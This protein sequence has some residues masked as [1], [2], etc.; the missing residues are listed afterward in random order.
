MFEALSGKWLVGVSGQ[1]DSMALLH[2]CVAHKMDVMACIINYGT[3]MAAADEI[4]YVQYFCDAHQIPLEVVD[5]PAIK[6][7]FQKRARDF[8]Y[9]TFKALIEQHQAQGVLLAHH[10]DDHL[11][12][13][14]WQFKRGH[15]VRFYGLQPRIIIDGMVVKRPLLNVTKPQLVAYNEKHKIKYFEDESNLSMRYTRNRIRK[16]LESFSEE[17]K[18]ALLE[19]AKVANQALETMR[20]KLQP[21]LQDQ[22]KIDQLLGLEKAEQRELLWLYLDKQAYPHS[23]SKRFLDDILQQV[24]TNH[25]GEIGLVKPYIFYYQAGF[26]QLDKKYACHYEY[27]FDTIKNIKTKYFTLSEQGDAQMGFHVFANDFPI[28]V[29]NARPGDKIKLEFGHQKLTTWFN[30]MRIPWHQRQCWP[31]IVNK[32]QE[33]IYVVGW[34]CDIDHFTNNP[35][36]FVL[37]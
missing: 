35:N 10:L 36:L 14:L 16:Q 25:V 8:R 23:I 30:A 15:R 2:M 24:Q 32:N 17:D 27:T 34:R 31:V 37:K 7:N 21:L 26:L 3:R 22:I 13:I 6:R 29:R 9:Q 20:A 4:A 12:T 11:E 33:L 1:N 18:Q 28:T 19:K 5:A